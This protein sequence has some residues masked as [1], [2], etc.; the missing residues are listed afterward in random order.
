MNKS[1]LIRVT[2]RNN[3]TVG[4]S[5]PEMNNLRRQF[6]PG[7]TKEITFEELQ[8][9]YFLKGGRAIL[10]NYLIIEDPEAV[11]ALQMQVEPEYFYNDNQIKNV[12]VNGSLD[13]F[14]DMLDFSNNGVKESIKTLAVNLPLNDVAKRQ[15]I[16]DKMGFDVTKAIEVKNAKF[17]NGQ[18]DTT[19]QK[20]NSGRRAAVPI[21][22]VAQTQK[23]PTRRYKVVE[24]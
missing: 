7:V 13:A 1:T 5:I 4:Y 21:N 16:L 23:A 24:E 19:G 22:P 15:A 2:N 12:M 18:E 20:H 11:K 9:L 17:D 6:A 10:D 3:G 8:N 14:L